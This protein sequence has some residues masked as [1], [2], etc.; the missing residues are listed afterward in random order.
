MFFDLNNTEPGFSHELFWQ[1]GQLISAENFEK[2]EQSL[3]FHLHTKTSFFPFQWGILNLKTE[4][5][6]N[7]LILDELA[8]VMPN[9]QIVTHYN[10]SEKL[11]LE[12]PSPLEAPE[13]SYNVYLICSRKEEFEGCQKEQAVQYKKWKP[14]LKLRLEESWEDAIVLLKIKKQ[15]NVQLGIHWAEDINYIP[16]VALVLLSQDAPA[17]ARSLWERLCEVY[18]KIKKSIETDRKSVV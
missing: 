17:S 5:N 11:G 15:K 14:Q 3:L 16:P 6:V 4:I 12:L 7:K 2:L 1:N 18:Q 10:I 9:G 8:L 13:E